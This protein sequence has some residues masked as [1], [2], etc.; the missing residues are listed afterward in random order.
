MKKALLLLLALLCSVSCFAACQKEKQREKQNDKE[1][2]FFVYQSVKVTTNDDA[3]PLLDALGAP[4]EKTI[5]PS[6]YFGDINDVLYVY[7]GLELTTY[8]NDGKEYLY[9]IELVNDTVEWKTPEGIAVG[10]SR[11]AVVKAYGEPDSTSAS[12]AAIYRGKTMTL[13]FFYSGDTVTRIAYRNNA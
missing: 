7:Q 13:N 11:Q 9:S 3:A 12:G 4:I 8:E 6:C 2:Y 5:S 10:A 1:N